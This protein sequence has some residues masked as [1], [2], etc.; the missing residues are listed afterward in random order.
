MEHYSAIEKSEIMKFQ[1]NG[2]NWKKIILRK[3]TQAP[4]NKWHISALVWES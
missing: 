3:V 2:W 4:K 1:E